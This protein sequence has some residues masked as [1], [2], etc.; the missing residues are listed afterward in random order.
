V[1]GKKHTPAQLL[2]KVE[3]PVED[4]LVA[5]MRAQ[6]LREGRDPAEAE[7]FRTSPTQVLERLMGGG[8]DTPEG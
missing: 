4:K 5:V 2:G 8:L 3:A 1:T 7:K 6:Y